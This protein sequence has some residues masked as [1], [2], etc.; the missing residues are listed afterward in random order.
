[1]ADQ[2]P[3][4]PDNSPINLNCTRPL[5]GKELSVIM[6]QKGKEIK[7]KKKS[8]TPSASSAPST[9][10]KQIH[11]AASSASSARSSAKKQSKHRTASLAASILLMRAGAAKKLQEAVTCIDNSSSI[12]MTT[13]ASLAPSMLTAKNTS[14]PST[15]ASLAPSMLKDPPEGLGL[16]DPP[17]IEYQMA[18]ANEGDCLM[19]AHSGLVVNVWNKGS[20]T[21]NAHS[22]R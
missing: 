4:A 13:T 2:F 10:K 18:A 15:A 11:L 8:H 7:G 14:H 17:Q 21:S 3:T 16:N 12:T 5:R 20:R 1:M 9:A 22:P 6:K 19:E